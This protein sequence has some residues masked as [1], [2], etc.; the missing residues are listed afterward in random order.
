M[1]GFEIQAKP[2]SPTWLTVNRSPKWFFYFPKPAY[3][4]KLVNCLVFKT[5]DD[6]HG[7]DQSLKKKKRILV[8]LPFL[9][10][11]QKAKEGSI[12]TKNQK[13]IVV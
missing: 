7:S 12:D 11:H 4:N 9:R 13:E 2:Y 5:V 6:S 3:V 8:I 10:K 1:H